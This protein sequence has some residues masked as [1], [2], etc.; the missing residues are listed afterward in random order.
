[1]TTATERADT[2]TELD[3]QGAEPTRHAEPTWH[4]EPAR[5]AETGWDRRK[6]ATRTALRQAA[7]ALADARGLSGVTVEE[8]AAEAGVSTRTFFNYFP[9]KEDAIIG[10]DPSA[11]AELVDHLLRR[12][13][14]ER[15]VEAVRHTLAE[16]ILPGDG[17]YRTL[18]R[19]LQVIRS[20]HHLVAHYV[21]RF[22]DTEQ[23]LVAALAERRGT[24]AATDRYAALVA[25]SVLAASRVALMA[26]CEDEGRVPLGEVMAEHLDALGAG[27]PE[28]AEA[29]R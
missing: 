28:P 24:D 9:T 23:A 19:R 11:I 26:W 6:R 8:I 13:A 17:D 15:P 12:P 20:D 3:A 18:L 10:W 25:A 7:V 4:A 16:V 2:A 27:L 21:L 1:M 22:G 5:H 14:H 29:R